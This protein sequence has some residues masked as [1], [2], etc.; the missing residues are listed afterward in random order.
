MPAKRFELIGKTKATIQDIDIQSLKMGQTDVKPAVSL[1]FKV[2]LPNARLSMLSATLRD[3]LYENNVG[4][5]NTTATLDG[6][7]VVSDKP[8][9]TE[10]AVALGALNW[11]YEQTGC[12]LKIYSGA[13]G[14]GNITLRDGTVRKMKI[15]CKEG[16]T[17]DHYFQF[18]TADVDAETIGELGILKSLER[19]VELTAPE[20]I[21]QQKTIE[22]D[23]EE[24][25]TPASALAAAQ[26]KA[27]AEGAANSGKVKRRA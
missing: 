20:I 19:D 26:A 17:V 25:L 16:G 22:D 21:S 5:S 7:E 12:T 27:D 4:K 14:H 18:Y 15:D 3:F 11:E 10:S 8:N 6:V 1:T 24:K 23:S 13:T 9:L 2:P